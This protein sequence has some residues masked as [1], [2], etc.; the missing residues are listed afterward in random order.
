MEIREKS[1]SRLGLRHRFMKSYK[2]KYA[3]AVFL[4]CVQYNAHHIPADPGPYEPQDG[5]YPGK[6]AFYGF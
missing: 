4:L 5:K 1:D 2:K 3:C 6:D